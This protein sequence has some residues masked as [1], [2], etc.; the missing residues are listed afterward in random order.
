MT[1]TAT[2]GSASTI[3]IDIASDVVC[4][5]CIIGYKQLERALGET[6]VQAEV[7]WHPF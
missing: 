7:H 5:W 3:R 1:E 6:G 4:P 2:D